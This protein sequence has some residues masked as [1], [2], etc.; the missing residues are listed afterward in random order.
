MVNV[1]KQGMG[2]GIVG[3]NAQ[4]DSSIYW[5]LV[6]NDEHALLARC[7]AKP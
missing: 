7:A 5:H 2:C 1:R 4:L 6:F 3:Q